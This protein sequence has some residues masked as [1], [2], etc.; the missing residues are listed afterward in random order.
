MT[1]PVQVLGLC[2]WNYPSAPGAFQREALGGLEAIRA[3]LYDPMRLALR[4]FFLEHV[5]LPPLRA[6]TDPDFTIVMLMGDQLPGETRD[7]IDTLI[8]DV[9]QIKPVYA[10]EGQPHQDICRDVMQS[11]RDPSVRA[12]A[13][14]RFDDDD[15]SAVDI[16]ERTRDVFSRTKALFRSGG[17]MALDFNRG[18]I[19]RTE[20][21]GVQFQPVTSRYWTP[22][23]VLFQR[24]QSD[25][26]LLDFN[27]AQ[28]WKRIPTITFPK[29]PMYL[30]GAHGGND[31]GV[32]VNP[33]NADD[34]WQKA[35]TLGETLL[36]RFNID[37]GRL[38]DAWLKLL[39]GD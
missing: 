16:V 20:S 17:K 19:L 28:L 27:H 34:A 6:Q 14:I 26:S 5:V 11:H 4:L 9:P 21:N 36:E 18:F 3:A 33:H 10:P 38:N 29:V 12:V 7:R 13:E 15:A 35:D 37:H 22:A 39:H 24:P 32:S 2:R 31:S 23:L 1:V 8:A 25:L 30:R